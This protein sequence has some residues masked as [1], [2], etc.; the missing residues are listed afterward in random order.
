MVRPRP[1]LTRIIPPADPRAV[2]YRVDPSA[3]AC[4]YAIQTR[5]D[6]WLQ[7]LTPE[8]TETTCHTSMPY[9][10]RRVASD[11]VEALTYHGALALEEV[12]MRVCLPIWRRPPSTGAAAEMI[13]L[14]GCTRGG[15]T[16]WMYW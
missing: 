16:E 9:C 11:T 14:S 15:S 10:G 8:E 6:F 13:V 12:R 7:H 4:L 1:L 3:P 2:R 5:L